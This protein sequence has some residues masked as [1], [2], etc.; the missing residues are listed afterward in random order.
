LLIAHIRSTR[1]EDHDNFLDHILTQRARDLPD[2]PEMAIYARA[3]ETDATNA[4][5]AKAMHIRIVLSSEP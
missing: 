2:H 4:G 1:M 3:T 5:R